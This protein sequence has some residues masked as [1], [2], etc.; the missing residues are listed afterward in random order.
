MAAS[1]R[2]SPLLVLGVLPSE[3]QHVNWSSEVARAAARAT[4]QTLPAPSVL[5][6]FV[7]RDEGEVSDERAGDIVRVPLPPRSTCVC[8]ELTH[9][10]FVHALR[11]WPTAKWY[12]KTEDHIY[13]QT[14]VSSSRLTRRPLSPAG[15]PHGHSC[16]RHGPGRSHSSWAVAPA[17]SKP[18]A[19]PPVTLPRLR[20]CA[21]TR[22]QVLQWEL[23]RLP[24]AQP[25]WLGLFFY[26]S[27]GGA[28][29]P[30][31]G[32][33]GGQFEDDATAS[34]KTTQQLVRA[35]VRVRVRVRVNPNP[36]PNLTLTLTL[37]LT[38]QLS[39]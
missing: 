35:R 13:V 30:D 10:W 38:L 12:G 26:S 17:P 20:T 34:G 8:A 37:S 27:V 32:C 25:V 2:D 28:R 6:R 22:S 5:L 15:A 29:R 7:L 11:T 36:N 16:H 33:W 3:K 14:S 39:P 1:P 18:P 9:A 4:W 21:P 19:S 24:H 23:E 31:A